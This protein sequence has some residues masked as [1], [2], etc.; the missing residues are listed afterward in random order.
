M[1]NENDKNGLIGKKCSI[2]ILK[3]NRKL[4]YTATILDLNQVGITFI[5]KNNIKFYFPAACIDQITEI[6]GCY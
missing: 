5:D 3:D 1:D 2:C 6:K 4:T